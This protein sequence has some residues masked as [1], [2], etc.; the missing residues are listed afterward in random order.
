[1][2][3][4][5]IGSGGREHAIALKLFENNE[6][7]KLFI[8]PGNG[9]TANIGVNI[10]LNLS[11]PT[12][13]INFCGSN[14]IKLVVIGPEQPLVDGLANL[15]R[16]NDILVFG[17]NKEAAM[18][19]GDKDFAKKLMV[20]YNVPT[21]DFRTFS[22]D[23]FEGAIEYLKDSQ[24]PIVLKAS[25]LA[26]GK[27]VIICDDFYGAK[28]SLEDMMKNSIFGASGDT[29]VVEEFLEG[30]EL[31]IFV[32]TDGEDYLVLPA[33][34][35]HKR[36]GENDT[37]KNTGG[38]GAYSPLKFVDSDFTNMIEETVIIPIL[39][40]L[41]NK[42]SK[43]NGCL[44]CGLMKTQDGIKVIEFN[45]RFGDPEIQAVIQLLEGDFLDLM[46]ST[47]K[48]KINK[49]SVKYNGGSAICVVVASGGYPDNYTKDFKIA[50]LPVNTDELKIIHA[51]T[52]LDKGE[53]YTSGGRVLNIVGISKTDD[54]TYCKKIAYS[55]L[56]KVKF[57]NIYFR[58]DIG[59]KA[60]L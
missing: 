29:V 21:A 20:E 33:S 11:N 12:E 26:A 13:I 35:D 8:S 36:I 45:C 23:N 34:Q 54:L 28:S 14:S 58:K 57:Q 22:K 30:D 52:K 41:R 19:E 37:G 55:A 9:G 42:K 60:N 31:S 17:P 16:E 1:M 44:Y 51:G 4:L 25:G 38:M 59:F 40:G 47:A 3:I 46:L 48:G 43:F 56:S 15:L 2:N 10:N 39:T 24:Y 49:N 6:N 32:V 5:I 50:G 53:F 7:V 27:G 18:I